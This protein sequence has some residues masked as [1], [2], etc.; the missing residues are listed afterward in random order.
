MRRTPLVY[1]ELLAL[2]CWFGLAGALIWSGDDRNMVPLSAEAL[3]AGPSQERWYGIFFQD[4][5]VGFSVSR[6]SL[7][8]IHI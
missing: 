6:Q 3:V 7:S 1:V 2:L 5:H 8:L 4:Q